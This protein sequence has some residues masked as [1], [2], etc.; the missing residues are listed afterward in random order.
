MALTAPIVF[1]RDRLAK[2]LDEQG[3]IYIPW[4]DFFDIRDYL[5][6]YWQV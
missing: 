3:K 6:Q 4:Q 1:A 5:A 2:Y